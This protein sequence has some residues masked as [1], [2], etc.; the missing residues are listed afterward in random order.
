MVLRIKNKI[1]ITLFFFFLLNVFYAQV[2][3]DVG[4]NGSLGTGFYTNSNLYSNKSYNVIPKLQ[5]SYSLKIGINPTEVD[6]AIVELGGFNRVYEF[7]QYDLPGLDPTIGYLQNFS[8]SGFES[9]LLYRRTT[10]SSFFEIGPMM[11]FNSNQII[12][13][14]ASPSNTYGEY[15]KKRSY[16]FVAG[17]GGFILGSERLTLVS[18]L[19]ILY[20]ISDLRSATSEGQSFPFQNYNDNSRHSALRGLDFQI[21]FELNVSMGF[22][23]RSKCGKRQLIFQW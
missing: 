7:E 2:W 15:L 17:I 13:D 18:G 22:L 6:A 9:A 8:F 14:E 5:N 10:E 19:R 23:Y 12:N 20:D 11:T 3:F 1:L 21:N 4:L 16:R